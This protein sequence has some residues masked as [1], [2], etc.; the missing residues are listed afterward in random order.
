MK[1][2]TIEIQHEV[3]NFYPN[4]RITACTITVNASN[5]DEA[6]KLAENKYFA[7]ESSFITKYAKQYG[8]SFYGV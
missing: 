5:W 7:E 8:L 4:Q 3:D 2:F 1:T 6:V